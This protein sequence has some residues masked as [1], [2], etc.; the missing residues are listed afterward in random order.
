MY[1][2]QRSGKG[3]EIASRFGGGKQLRGAVSELQRLL[4]TA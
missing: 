4:Y 1:S 2:I 3:T